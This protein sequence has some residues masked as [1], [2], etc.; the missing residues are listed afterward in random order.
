MKT[1]LLF[2]ILT[3][4]VIFSFCGSAS[5]GGLIAHWTFDEGTGSIAYDSAG[6]NDGNIVGATWTSG[7]IGGALEFDG[8]NNHVKVP[9]SGEL[10]GMQQITLSAW[11]YTHQWKSGHAAR[12]ISKCHY[13]YA[14]Y[15][16]GIDRLLGYP[17][18]VTVYYGQ[19]ANADPHAPR[20][21][22]SLNQWYHVVGTNDGSQQKVYIN[23]VEVAS[24]NVVTG[25]IRDTNVDLWIGQ[26][27]DGYV[28]AAFNGLIDDVR[29]YN[30]ALDENQVA[31]LY[32]CGFA[33]V[34]SIEIVGP[35]SV[36]EESGT[37]YKVFASYGDCGTVDIT[38]DANITV[39]PDEFAVI[40]VNGLLSTGRL[41]RMQET[42]TIYAD[43]R[44]FSDSKPVVIY[45]LCDG[46]E[47]TEQQLLKRNIA[48]TIE[49]KQGVMETIDY[50]M[51]IEQASV[52]ILS[53]I[54]QKPGQLNKARLQLLA[55]LVREQW[56]NKRIDE[57]IDCLETVQDIL[58]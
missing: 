50:A 17:T 22:I 4:L 44:G 20:D 10:D 34:Q 42:C 2:S 8:I 52:Q 30:Y 55:A 49:I 7:Q 29:I 11:I 57:S 14:S 28:S 9:D 33:E 37:Q 19:I 6:D 53:G 43:Y 13:P 27:T 47:C 46:N 21:T 56:A 51:K 16:M 18:I 35:N 5:A 26:I 3:V 54:P 38:A 23:G 12:I 48:D 25:P 15:E 31:A 41:Y 45:P 24:S 32:Q 40:D 58:K 36:P 39:A 1:N